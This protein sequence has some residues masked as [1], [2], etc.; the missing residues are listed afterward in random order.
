MARRN[1]IIANIDWITILLYLLMVFLGWFNIYAALYTDEQSSIFDMSQQYGKQLMWIGAA[2]II[3]LV[4]M[5]LEVNFYVFFSYILFGALLLLLLLVPFIGKEINGAR[6]WFQLGPVAFQPSEFTKFAT[7]LAL[8]RYMSSYGFKLLKTKSL[9]LIGAI[10]FAPVILILLQNDTGSALVY[11]SFVLVLY[12]EGLSGV[13]LFFGTLIAILFVLA[14]VLPNLTLTLIMLVAVLLMYLVFNP[15]LKQFANTVLLYVLSIALFLLVGLL[16]KTE[17]DS[18]YFILA[19]S[20]VAS[21]IVLYKS[22][23]QKLP[24]YTKIALVFIG[25]VLFTISVDYGFENFLEPHQQTRINELLG[26]E[27]NPH[28]AGYHVNQSKIAIGSGGVW[29]K[30]YLNGTQTKFDF[31]PEQSTDFIFCTV[32]EEW[33]FAGTFTII[34]LFLILLMRLLY[35][36]ERQR[37]TFSRIYGYSVAVILFFHFMVNIGM[38]IGLMPVI[39]IPLPFFSYGGSSLWSFTILLFIFIRLDAS[40]LE[41]LSG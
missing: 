18:S 32:G 15:K 4:V 36:A 5:L 27:S 38:T 13:V 35:L 29:G 33:G 23:K 41:Q 9:L 11:F 40:R 8:A 20:V 39:G 26:I 24:N 1:N 2:A 10:I 25:S 3:A 14:L 6:S 31:V 30:G 16:L 7:A 17:L 34:I 21:L 19:G 22:V 37:S 12:R 28:G